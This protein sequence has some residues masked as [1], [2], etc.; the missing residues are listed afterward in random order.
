MTG[1][2]TWATRREESQCQGSCSAGLGRAGGGW[3][4]GRQVKKR[5]RERGTARK[6]E[7]GAERETKGT[8][9]GIIQRIN[10]VTLGEAW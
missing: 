2:A 6:K 8:V 5:V 3:F 7:E 4:S 10:K 1:V 9:A